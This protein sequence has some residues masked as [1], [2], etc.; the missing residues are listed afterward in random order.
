MIKQ[1]ICDSID[2]NRSLKLAQRAPGSFSVANKG[3]RLL[4]KNVKKNE[5]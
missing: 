2:K 1:L 5:N 3:H 4:R